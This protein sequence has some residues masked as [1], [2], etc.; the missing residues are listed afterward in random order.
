MRLLIL[1]LIMLPQLVVSQNKAVKT[2][3]EADIIDSV[4][5]SIDRDDCGMEQLSGAVVGVLQ[6][7]LENELNDLLSNALDAWDMDCLEGLLMAGISGWGKS[8][9]SGKSVKGLCSALQGKMNA[10][11]G[12]FKS[13]PAKDFKDKVDQNVKKQKEFINSVRKW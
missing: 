6:Q 5:E 7:E 13:G 12:Q 3:S 11:A 9:V 1:A 10:N 4:N 2:M 8:A